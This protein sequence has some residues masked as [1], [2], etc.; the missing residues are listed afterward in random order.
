VLAYVTDAFNPQFASL[1]GLPLAAA[2]ITRHVIVRGGNGVDARVFRNITGV[3]VLLADYG[4]P[5]ARLLDIE[6]DIGVGF[7]HATTLDGQSLHVFLLEG[8]RVLISGAPM[9]NLQVIFM[10]SDDDSVHTYSRVQKASMPILA[11]PRMDL[12]DL[13]AIGPS[14]LATDDNR[15]RMKTG[16]QDSL[17]TLKTDDTDALAGHS[18]GNAANPTIAIATSRDYA[19]SATAP[20]ILLMAAVWS[21]PAAAA[22]GEDDSWYARTQHGAAFVNVLAFGA[23]GDGVT[24]TKALQRAIDHD[25]LARADAVV[26]TA[27]S[28]WLPCN[29]SLDVRHSNLTG[30]GAAVAIVNGP[31]LRYVDAAPLAAEAA[32]LPGTTTVTVP[33]LCVLPWA[34]ATIMGWWRPGAN[35]SAVFRLGDQEV[36]LTG[37]PGQVKKLCL[38]SGGASPKAKTG[39]G[40]DYMCKDCPAC[41]EPWWTHIAITW[42]STGRQQLFVNGSL[43]GANIS[44]HAP[45]QAWGVDDKLTLYGGVAVAQ[46]TVWADVLSAT[47]IGAAS[48]AAVAFDDALEAAT[49]L[50]LPPG[51]WPKLLGDTVSLQIATFPTGFHTGSIVTPGG[52]ATLSINLASVLAQPEAVSVVV[53]VWDVWGRAAAANFTRQTV[54]PANST[55]SVAA[56]LLVVDRGAFRVAAE[57]RSTTT[58][59]ILDRRDVGSFAAWPE[60]QP[61][62]PCR[63]D[64]FCSHV[65]AWY[66]GALVNQ[67]V[68]L[69]QCGGQR[70][71]DMLQATQFNEVEPKRDTFSFAGDA[72]MAPFTQFGIPV[73]GSLAGTP[74]WAA[75]KTADSDASEKECMGQL[76]VHGPTCMFWANLTPLALQVLTISWRRFLRGQLTCPTQ[77][78]SAPTCVLS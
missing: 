4:T 54:V 31:G 6:L 57:V 15:M 30:P 14:T 72:Q 48:T 64:F 24:D 11:E 60:P 35:T 61:G 42:D 49:P 46:L 77:S 75:N 50:P 47:S 22:A 51:K 12:V 63:S 70:D 73:L 36:A 74:A 45:S 68:R 32:V 59:E 71:H 52:S 67:S 53:S 16:S 10:K 38:M 20:I 40:W 58:G 56:T 19:T 7:T 8:T 27:L 23:K 17:G 41:L 2:N 55:A 69:G 78:F 18:F 21:A 43:L 37:P 1:Y 3:A 44:P 62:L 13:K 25:R 34:A 66:D 5:V 9:P 26:P 29:G 28:F 76:A 39:W 65:N 33:A